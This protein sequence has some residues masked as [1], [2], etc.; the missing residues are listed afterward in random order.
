MPGVRSQTPRLLLAGAAALAACAPAQPSATPHPPVLQLE[1]VMADSTAFN[2]LATIVMGPTEALLWDAQYHLDDARRLA[3]RITASGRRLTAIIISH[4]DHDHYAGAATI[5]ERFPGTPVYMTASALAEYQRSAARDFGQEKSRRPALFPDS[6]VTPRALP[7]RTLRVDGVTVEVIGDVAGD[8]VGPTNA[9]L[10]I[11][12]LRTLLASDV[13]F[14]GVHPWLGASDERARAGWRQSLQRIQA[15]RADSV[16][17][18]HKKDLASANTPASVASM[19]RYLA[20][21]DSIRPTLSAP[22]D[23]YRAMLARHPDR[24]IAVLLRFAAQRAYGGRQP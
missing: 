13:V 21:F 5:V 9:M 7:S 20:D 15:M 10:W 16:I 4:A 8:A 18:G 24:V 22:P 23:L 1:H 14:D 19:D 6:I 11:P 12:S 17:A 2:V 3:D